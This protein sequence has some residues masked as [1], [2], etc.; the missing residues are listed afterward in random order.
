MTKKHSAGLLAFKKNSGKTEV[1]LV[2]PGGPF[3]KN[4]DE[5]AWSIPKGEIEENEDILKAAIREFE[6]ETGSPV[7]GEFILLRP[8]KQKSGKI[9]HAWAA[10]HDMDATKIVSNTFEMEW[11]P[12][13]G[14]RQSFPEIDKG[15]WFSIA[16]ARKKI[17]GAQVE[18]LDELERKII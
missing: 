9:I 10:E 11:P 17:N 4:K 8:V 7:S 14:K 13:S 2:H 6:E 15:G 12:K 16:E 1:F 3:W 18:F 5:G